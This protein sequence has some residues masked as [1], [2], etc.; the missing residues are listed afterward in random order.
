LA[1]TATITLLSTGVKAGTAIRELLI[2]WYFGTSDAIDAYLI[3]YAVPYFLI[4]IIAGSLPGVLVPM[5]VRVRARSGLGPA[6]GLL[7]STLLLT[8]GIL[9]PLSV[10]LVVAAPA[11]LPFLA[12]GFSPE[13]QALTASLVL[14]L[15]P[16]VLTSTLI[17]LIAAT[18]NAQ[19]RFVVPA[20][21]PLVTTLAGVGALLLFGGIHALA[22][23]TLF[24]SAL[25]LGLLLVVLRAAGVSLRG[26]KHS[27][28][29][30]LGELARRSGATLVGSVL[31]AS[32]VL[33]DQAMTSAMSAGSVAA[34]NYATR[35]VTFP[36]SLTAGA[37]G[38]VALPHFSE[39]VSREAWTEI[40][41]ALRRYLRMIFLVTGPI[42]ALLI[43]FAQPLT[44]VLFA[45]GAFGSTEVPVVASTV[46]ALAVEVPF[47][48]GVILLMRVA[49]ALRLNSLLAMVSALSLV[50][51]VAL[52][53][54]LGSLLGVAGIALSTS[55]V[56]VCAFAVLWLIVRAR[57]RRESGRESSPDP[58]LVSG[59]PNVR[60]G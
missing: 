35:L 20:L 2:A 52:N 41:P 28:S 4:T 33:V 31:M 46:A 45:R 14:L 29:P 25:E 32:T 8:L 34:L 30:H 1:T 17:S 21:S 42:A 19:G 54:W 11:Y 51:N 16:L 44:S 59:P 15:A 18:L 9:A 36:L 39:M 55:F 56:Y 5:Y 27:F 12:R 43:I 22:A 53:A 38:T 40:R 26:T 48:T 58:E 3:A 7:V 49:L 6:S 37:L 50:V 57:L 47:Y 60:E 23:G 10:L 24:G 13:K